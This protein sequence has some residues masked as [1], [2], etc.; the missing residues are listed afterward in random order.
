MVARLHRKLR[1]RAAIGGVEPDL[2]EVLV[3]VGAQAIYHCVGAGYLQVAP[4]TSDGDLALN[5]DVLDDEP[6][7]AEAL[8]AAG[9]SLAVKPG[10][11]ARHA[12]QIDLMVPA[13]VGG[14]GRRSAR[15]GPRLATMIHAPRRERAASSSG[16]RPRH[17]R[18]PTSRQLAPLL[19]HPRAWPPCFPRVGCRGFLLS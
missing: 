2:C 8:R 6:L 4:F 1:E 12:V 3:L 15:L 16:Q 19:E 13:T 17:R 9:F 11:W 18:E 14:T 5:P 7:L 10:T